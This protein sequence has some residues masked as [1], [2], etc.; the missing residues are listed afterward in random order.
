MILK[1][2]KVKLKRF[3]MQNKRIIS[4]VFSDMIQ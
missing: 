2:A 4:K 1:N 3:K